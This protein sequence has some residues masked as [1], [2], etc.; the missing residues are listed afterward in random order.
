MNLINKIVFYLASVWLA[1]SSGT[2]FTEGVVGQ[3]DS[4]FPSDV[5]LK[6]ERT[7]SS[8]IYRDLFK[9]DIF[10]GL[11][12]DLAEKWEIS[13]DGLVYTITLK[14]DQYWNDGT[15]ITSDDMIY[16]SFKM[17]ALAGVA[18]DRVDDK[19][20]R[21]TL[22]NKFS[23]FLSLLTNGLMKNESAESNNPLMPVSNG[24]F[25]VISVNKNGPLIDEVILYN[26]NQEDNIRKLKFRFY[27]NEEELVTGAKLGEVEG[28]ALSSEVELENFEN[29]KFPLQ[30]V[31][32][33]I[34]FNL[35]DESKIDKT[36][37]EK[38][39]AALPVEE[40]TFPYGIPVQGV[41]SKSIYT[42][43]SIKSDHFD[44]VLADEF[45]EKSLT[46][47]VPSIKQH[48][49]LAKRIDNIWEDKFGLSVEVEEIDPEKFISEVIEPRD[50]EII[51]YG[52]EIG[53]DPDRYVYWHSTQKDFPNLNI[54]GFENVRADRALEE[55]RNS[56]DFA[57]RLVHYNQF[58]EAV[59]GD[60]PAI[61][62]YHPYVNYYVNKYVEG[63]G[64]KYTFNIWDR[65][66]DFNNWIKL[67][68][69]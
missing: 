60:V 25:R 64:E 42:K 18:T 31:Y 14:P 53:R 34:L 22:P 16:T 4:F 21:Y 46:L 65:F 40:L 30:G 12:T 58:Q 13:D 17:P 62:L 3:P 2:S 41:I 45:I 69:N 68:T 37:R 47:K 23:P 10:G 39:R 43:E 57:E 27:A 6:S 8:L 51:L 48:V 32:Y 26:T 44:K 52:Q 61:F 20:V 29:K 56:V 49:E 28:F 11:T 55:G 33:S 15:S 9:Y 63:L 19:T 59:E 24:Q 50:F 66:I 7:I 35:R 36:L 5:D 67:K 38:L 1:Y 54:T